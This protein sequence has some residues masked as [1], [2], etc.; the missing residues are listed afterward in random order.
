MEGRQDPHQVPS[1]HIVLGFGGCAC[2]R[3]ER[4]RVRHRDPRPH[5]SRRPRAGRIHRARQQRAPRLRHR[6]HREEPRRGTPTHHRVNTFR[7]RRNRESR[8]HHQVAHIQEVRCQSA[9]R[10]CRI[11]RRL[12]RRHPRPLK[13]RRNLLRAAHAPGRHPCRLKGHFGISQ[14][15]RR[16]G[17]PLQAPP[18]PLHA[19]RAL[20]PRPSVR[21]HPPHILQA[22]QRQRP[23]RRRRHSHRKGHPHHPLLPH[24]KG[25]HPQARG[26]RTQSRSSRATPTWNRPSAV[27]NDASKYAASP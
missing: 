2:G 4:L 3:M 26:R 23:A 10:R 11:A 15:C 25:L 24:R 27:S 14:R 1:S 8:P 19:P 22:A 9:G 5:R 12:P 21:R 7:K 17:K 6:H 13:S 18:R 20:H 16:V